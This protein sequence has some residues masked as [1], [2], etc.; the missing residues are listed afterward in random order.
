MKNKVNPTPENSAP[1]EEV[2]KDVEHFIEMFQLYANNP[3]RLSK[4]QDVQDD[5]EE[6]EYYSTSGAASGQVRSGAF[7]KIMRVFDID[8]KELP[9]VK[10]VDENANLTKLSIVDAAKT[11]IWE[12]GGVQ[13][14]W[15]DVRHRFKAEGTAIVQIG[16]DKQSGDYIPMEC[17]DLSEC[18]FDASM[19]HLA[20]DSRRLGKTIKTFIRSVQ[21]PWGEFISLY[22]DYAD[23]V[24]VGSPS[25]EVERD[26]QNKTLES[27]DY[28]GTKDKVVIHFAYSIKDAANPIMC[29]YA[30]SNRVLLD[31]AEGEQYPFWIKRDTGDHPFV[32]FIDAHVS[33]V[34]RGFYSPSAIGLMK[35]KTKEIE[36]IFFYSIPMFRK[37]VN[38]ILLLLGSKDERLQEEIALAS[39]MQGMGH[40]YII[41]TN[42]NV[43]VSEIKPQ[44][45]F[46]DVESARVLL[47]RELSAVFGF[48]VQE[49]EEVEQTAT[50]FVGKSKAELKAIS[51]LFKT[52]SGFFEKMA[53]YS[54]AL[55]AKF[56]KTNDDRLVKFQ[57]EL[58]SSNTTDMG[59]AIFMLKEF[60]G[61]F[62]VETDLKMPV[63]TADKRQANQMLIGMVN[64]LL[65]ASP[66]MSKEAIDMQVEAIE[67]EASLS[68][69]D[70]IYSK[71]KL[72]AM[73]KA[74]KTPVALASPKVQREQVNQEMQNELAPQTFLAQA[75]LTA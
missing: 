17:C 11:K 38:P 40:S 53:E 39:E 23:K 9:K 21:V 55:A 4:L 32:P 73:F 27:E 34:R 65:A 69:M 5:Y 33:N 52:N 43:Q 19:Q 62:K 67:F 44:S 10:P 26:T 28:S 31:K 24:N 41:P 1:I 8:A 51:G 6:L 13:D 66:Q 71:P 64:N 74:Q 15:D 12:D 57:D 14:V 22:P 50:E 3:A 37:A 47:S 25:E 54:V 58:G 68:D 29:V 20:G 18:Y 75:G 2:D 56:W 46:N 72:N 59:T 61:S 36:K 45:V 42:E 35:D 16:Y 7:Y 49:L 60:T 48:N 63:S 30:G 70:H